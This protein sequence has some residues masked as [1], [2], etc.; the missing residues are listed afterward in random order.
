MSVPQIQVSANGS[1][2][3]RLAVGFWRLANWNVS[4]NEL[5]TFI[6]KC[7]DIG[8]TT[9]DHADI[10]GNYICE[11]L[12]G[13]AMAAS[14][15]LRLK[16]KIV[17]KCGIKLLSPLRPEQ[18]I[19]Y[20]DT[21]KEHILTSVDNSLRKLRTDYIDVLLIHRPDPFINPDE[22][23]EAFVQL[24]KSGKV[25]HFGVSNF[26]PSQFELL[27]SRLEFPLVTN[28]IE[29]SVLNLNSFFDGTLDQCQMKRI[30]PMAW[31]PLGGGSLFNN[32]STQIERVKNTLHTIANKYSATVDR[33]ALAWLLVHSAKIIPVLGSGKFDRIESAAK[34]FDVPLTKEDWFTIWNAST[35]K[36]LP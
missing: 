30:S 14:A 32:N 2:F 6:H 34:A 25:L 27:Q 12:F 8:I 28:Q 4:N 33:T 35:G 18:K 23:A 21:G 9:F 13:N 17:T 1:V 10:Y 29:I 7:L 36:E 19:K 15:S 11:E 16:M 3:S 24:K 31:S 26:F 5:L 22:T 20:Y